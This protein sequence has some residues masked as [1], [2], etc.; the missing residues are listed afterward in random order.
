MKGLKA[1][2]MASLMGSAMVLTAV[3][4]ITQSKGARPRV[5][6][7]ERTTSSHDASRDNNDFRTYLRAYGKSYEATENRIREL[8]VFERKY[9]N[10]AE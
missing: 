6:R 4:G 8:Q 2:V 1:V 5:P 9:L 10:D 7:V 3:S